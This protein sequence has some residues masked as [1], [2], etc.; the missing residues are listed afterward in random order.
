MSSPRRV[1]G[2]I[3]GGGTLPAEIAACAAARGDGVHIVAIE[4]EADASFAGFPVTRVTWGQ[5]GG[6]LRA[7]RQ[8][9]CTEL[10]I[11]GRVKRPDL[12]TIIPDLGFLMNLPRIIRIVRGG[13]DDGVLSRVIQL[14]EANGIR[15]VGPA[16]V[17]PELLVGEGS[18]AGSAPSATAMSDAALG[19]A[20]I[21]VLGRYDIGQGVVVADGRI[22]A[23]EGAEGTDAMLARV[24]AQRRAAGANEHTAAHG[25]LVKGPKP[26]QELRIDL[27]AVGPE[28]V[29]RAAEARLEGLAVEA[30]RVIAARKADLVALAGKHGVFVHGM[31]PA[32]QSDARRAAPD[33]SVTGIT[34]L[35]PD[36]RQRRDITIGAGV[37]DTLMPLLASRAVVV[38]RRHV[39]AVEAGE[40][41]AAVLARASGLRQWGAGSKRTRAGVTVLASSD[42]IDQQ[43]VSAA[44]EAGLAGIAFRRSPAGQQP[45]S[46]LAV[47]AAAAHNVFIAA[48]EDRARTA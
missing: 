13:G 16:D 44:A 31:T 32:R 28:T 43:T 12:R 18:L 19:F 27:P 8:G 21:A 47:E 3:A 41:T 9:R 24:A 48:L 34:R 7:L 46:R 30:G 22:E 20:T 29:T 40:G 25:V 14:F 1:V 33:C 5:I 36:D 10:L 4:G 42:D 23:I 35:L 11:V 2:I 38:V 15:V 37:L 17:A 26:G 6:V 45:V 39:I